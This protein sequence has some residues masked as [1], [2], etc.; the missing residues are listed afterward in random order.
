MKKIIINNINYITTAIVALIIFLIPIVFSIKTENVFE[1]NKIVLFKLLLLGLLFFSTVKY[2][3]YEYERISWRKW[4]WLGL[5]MGAI[6]ASQLIAWCFSADRYESWHGS[7]WRFQGLESQ[8]YYLAFFILVIWN[9]SSKKQILFLINALVFSS[10]LVSIYGLIQIMGYDAITWVDSPFLWQRISSTLGQ[11]NFTGSFIIAAIPL[12]FYLVF[13]N[14]KILVRFF[15]ALFLLINLMAL[16]Y[17]F[18]RGAWLGL[19]AGIIGGGI[20][21]FIASRKKIFTKRNLA[22]VFIFGGILAALLLVNDTFREKIRSIEDFHLGSNSSRLIFWQDSLDAIKKKWLAGYG[23]DN[24]AGVFWTYYQ[25]DWAINEKINAYPDRAHNII[26]DILMTGGIIGLVAYLAWW[27]YVLYSVAGYFKK[28]QEA[29]LVLALFIAWLSYLFS[30]FFSFEVTATAMTGWFV[31]ALIFILIIN[32]DENEAKAVNNLPVLIKILLLVSMAVFLYFPLT[33][34]IK[35]LLA[36][37]YYREILYADTEQKKDLALSYYSKINNFFIRQDK[38][39]QFLGLFIADSLDESQNKD[40]RASLT[41]L[42]QKLLDQTNLPSPQKEYFSGRIYTALASE[43]EPEYFAKAEKDL[44]GIISQSPQMPKYYG[45]IA[46]LYAKKGDYGQAEF[47]LK[48]ALALLPDINDP[49]INYTHQDV[50]KQEAYSICRDLGDI[51]F[52]QKKY[53]EA[54]KYYLLAYEANLSDFTLL[55]KIADIYYLQGQFDQALVYV[56]HGQILSP[57]DSAWPMAI[58]EAYKQKGDI[59]QAKKYAKIAQQLKPDDELINKFLRN[60]EAVK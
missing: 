18:S 46:K 48:Q 8:L 50:I 10:I 44:K 29:N 33:E 13:Y 26:L 35:T 15:Y 30:L 5:F 6:I 57:K 27:F 49:R 4:A 60:F 25:K 23:Q 47:F 28:N 55:K 41:G 16:Y 12:N 11:P 32:K 39:N 34:K 24:Q 3:F 43:E 14:K 59:I 37:Y 36:D 58:A 17:T 54:G 7:L 51:F 31:A 19:V 53:A 56:K 9:I 1:L 22:A 52:K 21:Y 40:S 20:I 42:L 45:A 38:Y 2:L